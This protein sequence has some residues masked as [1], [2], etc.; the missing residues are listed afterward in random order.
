MSTNPYESPQAPPPF[1]PGGY[2]PPYGYPPPSAVN[3]PPTFTFVMF[4]VSL[5]FCVVRLLLVMLAVPGYFVIVK[6]MPEMGPTVIAEIATGAG[7]VVSGLI[8]N[9]LMLARKRIGIVFG[10]LLCAFTLGSLGVG[11]WQG[12]FRLQQFGPGTPQYVGAIIGIVL[13]IGIRLFLVGLY[14]FAVTQFSRWLDKQ[15]A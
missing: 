6:T 7:M 8:G 12:S 11:I 9:G 13:V 10:W 5:L 1:P 14:G 4:V 3:S 2:P 15:P